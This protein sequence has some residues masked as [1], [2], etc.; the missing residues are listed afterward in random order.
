MVDWCFPAAWQF[1]FVIGLVDE[2]GVFCTLEMTLF[3]DLEC[4]GISWWLVIVPTWWFLTGMFPFRT[5]FWGG[6]TGMLPEMTVFGIICRFSLWWNDW[7]PC[8]Y[9]RSSHMQ[10]SCLAHEICHTCH[11]GCWIVGQ[12]TIAEHDWNAVLNET[13]M[14]VH[15]YTWRIYS[16]RYLDAL[17]YKVW[18]EY[19]LEML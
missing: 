10:G 17:L 2:F 13:N 1:A 8:I 3:V 19:A 14:D 12:Q 6:A 11:N 18:T 4:P 5:V 15:M 9:H 16:S 7:C